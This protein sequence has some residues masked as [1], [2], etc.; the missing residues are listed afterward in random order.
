MEVFKLDLCKKKEGFSYCDK[1]GHYY[2]GTKRVKFGT[3]VHNPK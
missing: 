1:C 2:E 3:L